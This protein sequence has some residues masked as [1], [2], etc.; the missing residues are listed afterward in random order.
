MKRALA[1]LFVLACEPMP[2]PSPTPSPSPSPNPTPSPSPSPSSL[3][4]D[5][6][7][8]FEEGLDPD[9][10]ENTRSVRAFLDVPALRVEKKL[11]TV[12][13]PYRCSRETADAGD[14]LV[15]QCTGEDGSAIASVRAT[16]T[17]LVVVARDYGRIDLARTH[18]EIPL[19]RGATATVFAPA[20]YPGAS[21]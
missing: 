15:V 6:R 18:D 9:Y 7:I 21:R 1:L 17:T 11:F 5:A 16:P 20:H 8:R 12:P 14:D 4:V 10:G 19:P 13:F 3:N 2:T